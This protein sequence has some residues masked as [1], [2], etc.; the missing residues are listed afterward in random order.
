MC[1][2]V[3]TGSGKKTILISLAA[4]TPVERRGK[5]RLGVTNWSK[6]R[7]HL[8]K[9]LRDSG[10]FGHETIQDPGLDPSL[11]WSPAMFFSICYGPIRPRQ[12]SGGPSSRRSDRSRAGLPEWLG[13]REDL[14]QVLRPQ[15]R[16]LA[17]SGSVDPVNGGFLLLKCGWDAC[18]AQTWKRTMAITNENS[19]PPTPF[20][21]Q[22][23]F[24][25][26]C[27]S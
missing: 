20:D 12:E 9:P 5:E 22:S 14:A 24:I 11:T 23:S 25:T 17:P 2:F 21:M 16:S 26:P 7:Q 27:Y 13:Q 10:H 1:L 6:I 3:Q 19:N 18:F 4:C 15:S 8:N